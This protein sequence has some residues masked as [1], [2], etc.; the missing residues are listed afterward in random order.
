MAYKS[1][2]E[3]FIEIFRRS[4]LSISKFATLIK[5]DRRTVTAWIDN[6]SEVEPNNDIKEKICK[7]FR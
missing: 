4:N 6:I 7:V 1:S 5:K 3:K 2:V